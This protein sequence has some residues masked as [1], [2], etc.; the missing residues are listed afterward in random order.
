MKLIE[1]ASGEGP[2]Q[3]AGSEPGAFFTPFADGVIT[4]I[5]SGG[6]TALLWSLARF[7]AD[8][9]RRVLVTTTTKMG[10]PGEAAA[11]FDRF[12]DGASLSPPPARAPSMR[13]TPIVS[14]APVGITFA[15]LHEEGSTKTT[16]LPPAALSA[17][18]KAFDVT[19]IEGDGSRTLPLKG[20]ADYEP[21]VAPMTTVTVGVIPLW[22]LGMPA[23]EG[24]IH[25]LPLFCALTGVR[26]GERLSVGHLAA[27]ISGIREDGAQGRGLFARARGKEILF[28]NQIEDE[29]ALCR[30]AEVAAALPAGFRRRLCAVLA[31]SVKRG[32]VTAL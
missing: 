1:T 10:A 27:A 26:E 24:L 7:F 29:A 31:G 15:G 32:W 16:A 2:G 28:F 6:K 18:I 20:W 23:G 5:G 13:R 14:R 11:S 17:L 3:A 9:G 21:V 12:V 8:R 30:A 22:P 4:I 25:R 19:L